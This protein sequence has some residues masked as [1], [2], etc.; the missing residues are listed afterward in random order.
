MTG[1]ESS[2]VIVLAYTGD[3]ESSVALTWLASQYQTGVVTLTLDV[4]QGTDLSDVRERALAIGAL[5]AHVM[6]VRDEFA[7]TA[8]APAFALGV[9]EPRVSSMARPIVA[10]YVAQVAAIEGTGTV[11]H[12]SRLPNANPA[13][14]NALLAASHPALHVLA[15]CRDWGLSDTAII[16]RARER[17]IPVPV[18][19]ADL[20]SLRTLWGRALSGEVLREPWSQLPPGA[21][22]LTRLAD[23]APDTPA[24]LDLEFSNGVPVSLNG[25]AMPLTELLPSLETIAGSHGLGRLDFPAVAGVRGRIVEEAPAP[26]VIHLA[27]K[28]LSAVVPAMWP[29]VRGTVRL[30][31]F[32]GDCGVEEVSI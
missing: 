26:F 9:G 25:I 6:D 18:A 32:K 29:A 10:R 14:M 30:K 19:G 15:P 27:M 24:M 4:G 5:R 8:V 23:D 22:T 16:A 1:S 31:C 7:R 13:S 17:G 3:L 12:G 2:S 20:T 28:A 11:A 21:F